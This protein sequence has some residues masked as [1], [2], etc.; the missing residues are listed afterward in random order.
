MIP[1][2]LLVLF[3]ATA[4][5]AANSN[6]LVTSPDEVTRRFLHKQRERDL[7]TDDDFFISTSYAPCYPCGPHGFTTTPKR[8]I[9]STFGFIQDSDQPITCGT[10]TMTW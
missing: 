1:V 7:L 4:A 2:T 9:S 10:Y 6:D 5:A 3:A 8:D